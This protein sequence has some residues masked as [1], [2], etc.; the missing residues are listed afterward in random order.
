M[1]AY[2]YNDA[3]YITSLG[4]NLMIVLIGSALG[5]SVLSFV[6]IHLV[7]I[8]NSYRWFKAVKE[9]QEKELKEKNNE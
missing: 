4:G 3:F 5:F 7:W 2:F 8:N 9:I 6:V 1:R